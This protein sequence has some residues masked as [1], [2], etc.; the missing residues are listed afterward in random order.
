MKYIQ[1]YTLQDGEMVEDGEILL[2]FVEGCGCQPY[3]ALEDLCED[4]KQ[5][6][7]GV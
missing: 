4:C 3:A 6:L 7:E 1:T 2:G 5:L